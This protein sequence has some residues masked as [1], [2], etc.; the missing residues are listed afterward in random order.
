MSSTSGVSGSGSNAWASMHAQRQARMFA[1]VDSDGSGSVDKTELS[2]M[3]DKVSEKTGSSFDVDQAFSQMDSNGDGTL[4]SDELSDG[5]KN[6]MPPPPSTMDFAQ[7][8]GASSQ[9]E[10]ELFGKIDTNGDG[11]IDSDEMKVFTDKVK[12]DTGQDADDMFAKLDSDGDGKVSQAEFEAGK[13]QGPGGPQGA[14]GP[15]PAGGPRGDAGPSGS[16]DSKTY[17]KLDTNK[18]GVVSEMER[19]VGELKNA[20]AQVSGDGSDNSAASQKVAD[21]AR[22]LY[23]QLA[24]NWSGNTA[25]LSATA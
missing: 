1:K 5:M 3:L 8:R 12:S 18:D 19:L 9:Q 6:L 21:L 22:Q 13:P 7:S 10:D 14:K 20:S 17:D 2:A 24:A 25:T 4:S 23:E 16:S 15:P 11:S